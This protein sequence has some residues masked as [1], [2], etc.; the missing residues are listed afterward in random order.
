MAQLHSPTLHRQA[1]DLLERHAD[2]PRKL[3]LLHT[4]IALGV[5]LLVTVLN[6]LLET[7]VAKTGGLDGMATRSVLATAQSVL[8]TSVVILLPFWEVGLLFAALRWRRGHSADKS[9]L[10]EGFRRFVNVFAL[11]FWSGV[12]Y[13]FLGFTAF[14]ISMF[15]FSMTP[16]AKPVMELF[17]P[18]GEVVTPEQ[19]AEMLTPELL[20]QL[21]HRM[22]PLFI[23][24]GVLFAAVCIPL[25]YRLRFADFILLEGEGGIRSMVRSFQMTRGSCL[26]I[27]KLDLHFWWFY[28]LH[29]LCLVICYGDSIL[30][31]VGVTL[32][33]SETASAFLFYGLGVL[34]QMLLFWRYQSERLTTYCL[35]YDDLQPQPAND[36]PLEM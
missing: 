21:M 8:D 34:L 28:L 20:N 2:A 19:V 14:Q 10:L 7:Q 17:S 31:L 4:V 15:L 25:S 22:T 24:F 23:L 29:I 6:F 30:A 27:F 36:I 3:V 9:Y 1:K 12:V 11:R 13:I 18:L 26:Q 33:I 35:A 32:P 5:P 16:W